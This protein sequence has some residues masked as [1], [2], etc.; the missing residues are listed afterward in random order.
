[1]KTLIFAPNAGVSLSSGGGTK[2]ALQM[3]EILGRDLHQDVWLAGYHSYSKAALSEAHGVDLD[4]AGIQVATAGSDLAFK[5]VRKAPVKLSP[6]DI[7]VSRSFRR[8]VGETIERVD[9]ESVWFHDD[10]PAAALPYLGGLSVRLYVHFPLGARSV[11]MTPGLSRNRSL[12]ESANDALLNVVRDRLV[13]SPQEAGVKEVWVNSSVTQRAVQ[14]LWGVSGRIVYLFVA[15]PSLPYDAVRKR[16]VISAVGSFTRA[17][18]FHMLLEGFAAAKLSGWSLVLA[19]HSR[20]SGYLRALER[21]ARRL[22]VSTSTQLRIDISSSDM[23]SLLQESSIVCNGSS[24]EPFGLS[25]LE[26]MAHGAVPVV[27]SSEYSGGWTDISRKGVT[28]FGFTNTTELAAILRRLA[29]SDLSPMAARAVERSRDFNRDALKS[30][31]EQTL[32]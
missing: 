15:S 11:E 9:P 31:L 23:E 1:V 18:G 22:G 30:Q 27:R 20:E 16:R 14:G 7:L 5:T 3:A 32:T 17:K 13:V 2:G 26:G 12:A 25:L 19:G 8:W 6:Y 24:F 10:I 4:G 28:G 21:A 29:S